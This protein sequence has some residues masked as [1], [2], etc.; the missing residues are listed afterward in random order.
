MQ[1]TLT[2][3]LVEVQAHG[4]E[5]RGEPAPM[6]PIIAVPFEDTRG[7]LVDPVRATD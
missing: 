3:L 5:R 4:V 7:N 6:G 2:S 1:I